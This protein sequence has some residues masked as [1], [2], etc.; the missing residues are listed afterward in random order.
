M[1]HD[2]AQRSSDAFQVKLSSSG[3]YHTHSRILEH[4]GLRRSFSGGACDLNPQVIE[5]AR[6]K[7]R[8]E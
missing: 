2:K 4:A 5:T 6:F 8:T 1:I 7:D 3:S